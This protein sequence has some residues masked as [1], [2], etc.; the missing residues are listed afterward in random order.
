MRRVWVVC[1]AAALA[2]CGGGGSGGGDGDGDQAAFCD[3]L[4]RLTRNDPFLVFGDAA[5]A[6][7]IEVAFEALVERAAELL[8]VAPPEAR[9]AA[10]DYAE[11]AE[12]L[13]ALLAAAG[14]DG[15]AVDARAYREQQVTYAEAAA[16]L[17][18]YLTSE[19]PTG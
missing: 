15:A 17:E 5:T 19:C 2:A 12:A 4:D 18:R 7:E 13:D 9:A 10:R 6:D 14:Y 8:D 16:R 1:L 11:S 3:R